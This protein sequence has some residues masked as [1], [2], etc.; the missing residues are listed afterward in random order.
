MREPRLGRLRFALLERFGSLPDDDC[1]IA[2]RTDNALVY[3]SES[4]RKL[5]KEYGLRQEF[6]LPHTPEQ[7]GVA[8][9]F[10]G[11]LKLECAWQHRFRTFDEAKRIRNL[12][13]SL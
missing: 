5:A 4:Y 1:G 8:E 9:S 6:I 11:S 13:R 3:A 2:L 7:N 10:M 12:D